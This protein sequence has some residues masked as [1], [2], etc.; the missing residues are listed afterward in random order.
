MADIARPTPASA[1]L[2]PAPLRRGWRSGRLGGPTRSVVLLGAIYIVFSI[3]SVDFY[4]TSNT[5]SLLAYA[6]PA[7]LVAVGQTLVIALG[8]IDLSV[9][10][11][12]VLAGIVLIV[13][14]PHGLLIAFA[15]AAA[16]G[17]GAGLFNGVVTAIFRVP[18]LVTT[19]ATSFIAQGCSFIIA[20]KPISGTR[21]DLTASLDKPIGELLTVRIVIGVI[22][23]AVAAA[24]F[25]L[26]PVGRTFF[27]R[28]SN[29][30]GARLLGLPGRSLV[31]SGFLASGLLATAAGVILSISLDS[32]SPVIGGDL[33][34]LSIAACLIGGSRLEGGTGSVIGTVIALFAL[35]ALQNGMDI[36]GISSY[37]QQV[38]RGVVVLVA[39]LAATPSQ[40]GGVRIMP[41]LGLGGLR[42]R[43]RRRREPSARP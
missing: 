31:I 41:S 39:L 30:D 12:G 11:V 40:V 37:W 9:A 43:F 5:R 17:V 20:S 15:A 2:L 28:G 8:E 1:G 23:I 35:L 36:V 29:P 22:V 4:A 38:V 14:E 7:G 6:V 33:L 26:T 24:I 16:V 18:S 10:S 19:L 34:L 21:L 32:G 42:E 25:G 3:L 13:L 27:A